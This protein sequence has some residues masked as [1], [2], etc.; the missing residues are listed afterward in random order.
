MIKVFDRWSMEGIAVDDAG[1][2]PY[3]TLEPRV[4][5]KT[6][7]RYAKNRFHK[8]R[9]FIVERLIN[10]I[11]IPGHKSKKHFKSSGRTT[12][13]AN[14]SLSIMEN[15]F[16]IIE[17][18]TKENPLKVFVKAL[19]NAAPREEIITIEYGGARYPKAVECAPQRRVDVVLR[20]M[21]QGAY[22]KSFNSKKPVDDYLAE[23]ILNAY[24]LSSGS[25]AISKKLEVERQA[26]ASR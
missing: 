20:H 2:K 7:A 23:E 13:K 8:S 19:E 24:R 14:K 18:Q 4:V 16:T 3:I 6:G 5:P 12:G 9:I 1:L 15:V 25:H 11:M 26:D 21:A 22:H 17:K 10:K